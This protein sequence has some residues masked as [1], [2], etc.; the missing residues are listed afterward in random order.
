MKA[1]AAVAALR[2]ADRQRDQ[3]LR[4]LVEGAG[5]LAAFASE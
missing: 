5:V 4:L 2:H 3:P 1:Y